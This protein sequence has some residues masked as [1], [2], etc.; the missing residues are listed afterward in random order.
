[1][2][3]AI[4]GG[5]NVGGALGKNLAQKGHTLIF[6]LRNP[7]DDK[8]SVLK[9]NPNTSLVIPAE[10]AKQADVIFLATPWT[11]TKQA[12]ES[13]GP[14][15]GKILV[16]CTNPIKPDF[17]GLEIGHTTSGG[18]MIA[19]WAKGAKVVKCF[20]HTFA[21]NMAN[22]AYG[23]QKTVIFAAGDDPESVAL[24]VS[25]ASELGFDALPLKGLALA[26]QLEQF[27]WLNIDLAYNQGKGPTFA[28]AL[29]N[30]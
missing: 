29:L 15:S 20:N 13:L 5:G 7:N 25:L 2:K 24:I 16:D 23:K 21:A 22:P 28:F 1:M 11:S 27:A 6:G 18:E 30:R 26:R 3:I 9:M 19:G 10:A 14:I 17:S 4:I 8:Y 12:L